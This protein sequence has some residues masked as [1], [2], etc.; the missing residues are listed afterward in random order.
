MHVD[1]W[2]QILNAKMEIEE[3]MGRL[4]L[5]S[6]VKVIFESR[7]LFPDKDMQKDM[8]GRI[9]EIRQDKEVIHNT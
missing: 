8:I 6:N 7:N 2:D 1:I 4:S 9:I 5:E 3:Q